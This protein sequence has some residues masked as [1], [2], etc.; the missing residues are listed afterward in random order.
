MDTGFSWVRIDKGNIHCNF[1]YMDE[2]QVKTVIEYL[3]SYYEYRNV[4]ADIVDLGASGVLQEAGDHY[5]PSGGN[6]LL[7]YY[8]LVQLHRHG[9]IIPQ[10]CVEIMKTAINAIAQHQIIPESVFINKLKTNNLTVDD[11]VTLTAVAA[12]A[13]PNPMTWSSSEPTVIS[14]TPD[15]MDCEIKAEM[16]G[17]SN[18]EASIQVP[19]E[20][21]L[22]LKVLSYASAYWTNNIFK[23]I[24]ATMT[25]DATEVP[26]YGISGVEQNKY[27]ECVYDNAAANKYKWQEATYDGTPVLVTY[28]DIY[29]L[30]VRTYIKILTKDVQRICLYHHEQMEAYTPSTGLTINWSSSSDAIDFDAGISTGTPVTLEA[31]RVGSAVISARITDAFGSY[32]DATSISVYALDVT[33]NSLKMV[34]GATKSLYVHKKDIFSI[35]SGIVVEWVTSSETIAT[36]NSINPTNPTEDFAECEVSA[37]GVGTA[38]ITGIAEDPTDGTSYSDSVK[39]TVG[40]VA[41]NVP[42]SV[43]INLLAVDHTLTITC[44]LT[45]GFTVDASTGWETGSP[46][47][48][49]I[50]SVSGTDNNTVEIEGLVEGTSLITVTARNGSAVDTDQIVVRVV[51]VPVVTASE[52]ATFTH[53]RFD[54]HGVI[55]WE[56]P[57]GEEGTFEADESAVDLATQEEVEDFVDDL[58]DDT[59]NE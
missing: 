22:E 15:N 28:R 53:G 14:I 13:G 10:G 2:D 7:D 33:P 43:E 3:K 24:G 19:E 48:V 35:A 41:I 46:S 51:S 57:T 30:I 12:K 52:M 29:E 59:D 20:A 32:E 39:V 36:I 44:D 55:D 42:A 11:K 47:V 34:T 4:T 49:Q 5:R 54:G 38:F 56:H 6:P 17:T 45:A 37:Q 50:N 31:K 26:K 58:F 25:F 23:Y 9:T 16:P 40:N 27:Y 8:F 21:P 1:R 18:I